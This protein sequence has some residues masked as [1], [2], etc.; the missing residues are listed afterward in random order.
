MS[1]K[2][3]NGQNRDPLLSRKQSSKIMP[4]NCLPPVHQNINTGT[5]G[6]PLEAV[7]EIW[8]CHNIQQ[9]V[10]WTR[11]LQWLTDQSEWYWTSEPGVAQ[12][13]NYLYKVELNIGLQHFENEMKWRKEKKKRKKKR[14][15]TDWPFTTFSL[16]NTL[17]GNPFILQR[18]VKSRDIKWPPID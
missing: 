15:R 8:T 18:K 3:W 10:H 16:R 9:Q 2:G 6:K 12:A 5:K 4:I 13:A 11:L 14:E 17:E 1:R 7:T